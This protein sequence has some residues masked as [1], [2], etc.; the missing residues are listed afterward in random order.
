MSQKLCIVKLQC[1][2]LVWSCVWFQVDCIRNHHWISTNSCFQPIKFCYNTLYDAIAGN[3]SFN[4]VSYQLSQWYEHPTIRYRIFIFI[5]EQGLWQNCFYP[6]L[7]Y[8]TLFMNVIDDKSVRWP[9][10][11]SNI[12]ILDGKCN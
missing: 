6:V 3:I 10:G 7:F 5:H 12:V 1:S 11:A 4:H 2:W 8:A 9:N